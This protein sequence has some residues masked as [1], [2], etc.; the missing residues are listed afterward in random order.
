MSTLTSRVEG[1]FTQ[2][3]DQPTWS[4]RLALAA[5][6]TLPAIIGVAV[7][8]DV[9]LA[10]MAA[11]V[12]VGVIAIVERPMVGGLV[13]VVVA[14]IGSGI[15]AGVPVPL[16]RPSEAAIL[17]VGALFFLVP[18]RG[19]VR[20]NHLDWAVATYAIGSVAVGAFH[21]IRAGALGE[22]LLDVAAPLEY[23]LLYRIVASTLVRPSDRS[24]A[25][26]LL[27]LSSIPMSVVGI[28]QQLDIGPTRSFVASTTESG[29]FG[30]WGYENMPR[31]TSLFPDWHTFGGYLAVILL[32]GVARVAVGIP[33]RYR[34]ETLMA[35]SLASAALALTQ[36]FTSIF[37]VAFGTV[38]ILRRQRAW[39]LARWVLVLGA[40]AAAFFG[41]FLGQRLEEQWIGREDSGVLP[42]TIDYRIEVW[43]E[44]YFPVIGKYWSIGYGTGIP[45]Q[46]DW[47][48]T[49]SGY[50]SLLFRGGLPL[51]VA[52]GIMI[53]HSYR[54][55]SR[56]IRRC[57]GD[58]RVLGLCGSALAAALIPMNMVWPYLTN[59]GLSQAFFVI[60]GLVRAAETV[61]RG[62]ESDRPRRTDGDTGA[63]G[64]D[65]PVRVIPP[66]SAPPDDPTPRLP[67]SSFE[68][69]VSDDR[70]ERPVVIMRHAPDLMVA[71]RAAGID[72][73]NAMGFVVVRRVPVLQPGVRLEADLGGIIGC[74]GLSGALD[75]ARREL[76][77]WGT[78]GLDVTGAAAGLFHTPILDALQGCTSATVRGAE[79]SPATGNRE[80]GGVDGT[81]PGVPC[82]S[83]RTED[84]A[85]ALLHLLLGRSPNRQWHRPCTHIVSGVADDEPRLAVRDAGQGP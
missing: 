47:V 24:T 28:L 22:Q 62:L 18:L 66:S 83:C 56:V 35:M 42:Q 6:V 55:G 60:I 13:L 38:L 49:E 31:A 27:V 78:A 5:M 26:R 57:L 34:F 40:F 17:G 77:G 59:S 85:A 37:A 75:V 23:L 9:G 44:Q 29:V 8:I 81:V 76:D 53:A 41:S 73:P 65:G 43:T 45:P 14:P 51:L 84:D 70:V 4:Y 33:M 71:G 48:Y 1:R 21:E 7:V 74:L 25:L 50:L 20:W 72:L 32:V 79:G 68:E 36:T 80:R 16:L 30:S 64:P 12:L 58:D 63:G 11:L 15:A 3:G 52:A 19:T 69:F 46:I 67:S 10:W 39:H 61:D 82:R 2:F 54:A